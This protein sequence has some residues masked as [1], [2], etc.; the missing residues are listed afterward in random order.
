[1]SAIVKFEAARALLEEMKIELLEAQ[2]RTPVLTGALRDSGKVD[3][4][5]VSDQTISCQITFGTTE[6]SSKYAIYVH[7]DLEAIH[8]T[9]QAKFLESV[10]LES[11]PYMAQRVGR[12][13]D[14]SKMGR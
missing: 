4:P 2:R 6:P 9:G 14:L 13:I 7:E 12:R 1:M 11:A 8:P 3:L 10:I 5:Q